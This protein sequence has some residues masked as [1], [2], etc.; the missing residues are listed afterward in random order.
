[1]K[2]QPARTLA[3]VAEYADR[4]IRSRLA[5]LG[6]PDLGH[7]ILVS[8]EGGTLI[9]ALSTVEEIEPGALTFATNKAFLARVEDS[10]AAAVILPPGLVSEKKPFLTAPLPRLVFSTA[11]ELTVSGPSAI[12]AAEGRIGFK[13]RSSVEIGP[14]VVIGDGCWIGARVKIGR[15]CRLYP[16]VYIDDDVEMGEDCLIYPNAVLFR[17]TR[18]GRKVTVHAGAV[19]GDDGFGYNQYFDPAR[20]RLHHL[21]N[22]H[23]GGVVLED[24][25]EIGSNVCI[26]RGL[27]GDTTIGAGTKIDNLVQIGHNV[28]VGRESIIVGMV[29][30]AGTAKIGS[31][32]FLLGQSGVGQGLTVG[33]G[34]LVTGQTM[35]STD[36]PAGR[37]R[38]AGRPVQDADTEWRQ[39]AI[40]R[41]ELPRLRDF[42]R[43]FKKAESFDDLKALF[44]KKDISGEP[45]GRE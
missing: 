8:G 30:V 33:D 2:L 38:W 39:V 22:V 37:K 15:G 27:A 11:L 24:F 35:V 7:E 25:V 26:D 4:E 10:P 13:D 45:E 32:V 18:L 21:K 44:F 42:F 1:M 3:E 9:E 5:D 36:I 16:H 41:K 31:Q 6:S 40:A 29:G 34:A 28:Q 14:D 19:I 17:K 23:V 43:F 20:E 12:P